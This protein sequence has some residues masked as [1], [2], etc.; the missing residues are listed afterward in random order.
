MEIED[1][2]FELIS[3]IKISTN[4][5]DAFSNCDVALLIGSHPHLNGME[6]KDLLE[7]NHKIFKDIGLSL[8]EYASPNCK[9]LVIA[10]PVNSLLTILA[11]YAEKI[12]KKNLTGLSRLDLNRAKS[13]TAKLC[14]T[15]VENITDLIVWG[16]HSDTQYPDVTFS[17]VNGQDIIKFINKSKDWL[18][19]EFVYLIS[20]RWKKIVENTGSTR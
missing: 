11:H 8:N 15:S 9:I 20:N 14:N 16:N 10:N 5:K 2:A 3:E 1:C 13:L 12:P 19:T 7:K 18:H 17:K 6:R 4:L